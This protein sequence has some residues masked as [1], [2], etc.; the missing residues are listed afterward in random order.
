MPG[1]RG[2]VGLAEARRI[3]VVLVAGIG[4]FVMATPA[5]R[6][7]RRAFPEAHLTFL[8]SPPVEALARAC[9]YLNEILAFDLRGYRPG[10]RGA[11]WRAWPGF[12]SLTARLRGRRFDL[13][14][15]LY[16]VASL[17]GALR[18]GLLMAVIRPGRTAGRWSGGRGL[19]FGV[20]APDR[21]HEVDAMLALAAAVGCPGEGSVPQLWVPDASRR[22]AAARLLEAGLARDE[23]YAVL[24]VGSYR[25]EARLPAEKAAAIAGGIAREAGL[26]IVLGGDASERDVAERIARTVGQ[27]A[28]SVAGRTDLLELAA[29]FER[30]RVVVTTDSGPMHI[31]AATGAPLVALFG[32]EDPAHTGPRGRP[33][34]VVILRGKS[35][36][37]DPR[38][39]HADLSAG[40]AVEAA[41]ELLAASGRGPGS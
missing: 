21:P 29:L 2:A 32:P 41:L 8:T 38:A 22:S 7:I 37:R 40:E 24:S 10:G 17:L 30:A 13:G 16:R 31:A 20:R 5:L 34:Q 6:A 11:G 25:P 14:V 23:P 18:M 27:A 9:P 26:R 19:F 4:D 35:K 1:R 3:L 28:R 39:W 15:N 33:G 36:P 12:W